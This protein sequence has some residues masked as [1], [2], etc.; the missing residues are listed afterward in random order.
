MSRVSIACYTI[1][2]KERYTNDYYDLDNIQGRNLNDIMVEYLDSLTDEAH[3]YENDQKAIKC[4]SH[5]LNRNILNGIMTTGEYGFEN[6]LI[7][8]EN[9]TPSYTR[10]TNDVEFYPF[11]FLLEVIPGY[12]EA[13]ILMQR[14]G[15]LGIRS[16]MTRSL[17]QFINENLEQCTIEVLPLV[18]RE[19]LEEYIEEGR[20]RKFRFIRHTL[21][22]DITDRF[23]QEGVRDEDGYAEYV[24]AVKSRVNGIPMTERFREFA[25]GGQDVREFV[26]LRDF[27]YD[28]VKVE[29]KIN[30]KTR[31]INLGDI[32]SLRSY[33]DIHDDVIIDPSGHPNFESIDNEAKEILDTINEQLRGVN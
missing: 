29:L 16:M 13:V 27:E 1:R 11:Y 6:E 12:N 5:N 18:P 14:F 4:R 7:D 17:T 20:I 9:N 30:N 10:S 2:I 23:E 22:R 33:I 15:N 28:T 8:I 24:V 21:P 19:L 3:V 25:N 26:E 31:T 32:D